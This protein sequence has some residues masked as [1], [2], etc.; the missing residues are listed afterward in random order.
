MKE[1]RLRASNC[2]LLKSRVSSAEWTSLSTS[3]ANLSSCTCLMSSM[4]P[5]RLSNSLS[6]Y[7]SYHVAGGM[8]K[9]CR[10]FAQ[11]NR[12]R[13]GHDRQEPYPGPVVGSR[14]FQYKQTSAP[15]GKMYPIARTPHSRV[16]NKF[17]HHTQE[18]EFGHRK[19]PFFAKGRDIEDSLLANFIYGDRR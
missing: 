14:E 10:I 16:L 3:A 17:R 15:G 5:F 13:I 7:D 1:T 11:K 2:L 18:P 19:V 12:G 4:C 9:T 8:A 6:I